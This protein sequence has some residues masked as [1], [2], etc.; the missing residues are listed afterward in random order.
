MDSEV[1]S[2][3][4]KADSAVRC[5]EH[6]GIRHSHFRDQFQSCLPPWT[7]LP[8]PLLSINHVTGPV[9]VKPDR[10]AGGLDLDQKPTLPRLLGSLMLSHEVGD[11]DFEVRE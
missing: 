6:I 11:V 1:S 4:N 2:L 10:L 5:D 7:L 9:P 8:S 3:F